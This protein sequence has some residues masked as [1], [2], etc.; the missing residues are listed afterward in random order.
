MSNFSV[1]FLRSALD[2]LKE[3]Y[4]WQDL[5]VLIALVHNNFMKNLCC[6]RQ[7]PESLNQPFAPSKPRGHI[8]EL[9]HNGEFA[10][11]KSLPCSNK[12]SSHHL[13]KANLF[14]LQTNF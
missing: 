7:S 4:D 9:M 11:G 8:I 12:L 5:T 13:L 3:K 14:Q 1:L 10:E 6:E 2:S